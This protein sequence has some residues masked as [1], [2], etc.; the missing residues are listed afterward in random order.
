MS[1]D[2][3]VA[4][5]FAQASALH[6]AR[7]E[8]GAPMTLS[9]ALAVAASATPVAFDFV[10]QPDCVELAWTGERTRVVNRC[11]HPLL[12]D[13]SVQLPQSPGWIPPGEAAEIRDLSAFTLGMDGRLY[14]VVA[15]VVEPAAPVSSAKAASAGTAP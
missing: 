5:I 13:Q 10:G 11:E 15:V 12:V 3:L 7:V 8:P 14:R 9:I 2:P 4:R 6:G 1:D